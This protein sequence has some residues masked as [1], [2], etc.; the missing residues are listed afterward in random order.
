ML[1]V[2]PLAA[3][4]SARLRIRLNQWAPAHLGSLVCLG[5]WGG[6]LPL[7]AAPVAVPIV[8]YRAVQDQTVSMRVLSGTDFS[9]QQL[10]PC[11][12]YKHGVSNCWLEGDLPYSEL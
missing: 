4:T 3:P 9:L 7:I 10:V 12:A 11:L 6:A 2:L 1:V 8:P 5:T